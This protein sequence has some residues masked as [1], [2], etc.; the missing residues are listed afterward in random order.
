MPALRLILPLMA[1]CGLAHA[2]DGASAPAAL[3]EKDWLGD[4]PVVLSAARLAQPQNEAPAAM[5]VID[6]DAIRQ[7][8]ARHLVDLLRLVPGIQVAPIPSDS[9]T[10]TYHGLSGSYAR[11]MQV[12]IDGRSQYSAF[13]LGGVNWDLVPVS[14]DDI[15]RIEVVRGSNSAAFGSNAFLG[16]VNVVTRNAADTQGVAAEYRSGTQGVKDGRLRAGVGNGSTFSMRVT[17]DN[18]LDHGQDFLRDSKRQR[19]VDVRADWQPMPGDDVEVHL[20]EVV[21]VLN[22]G[23]ASAS[24]PDRDRRQGQQ[25]LQLG[26]R[27]AL[28]A[29]D[30]IALNFYRN[31]E[32]AADAYVGVKNTY[33]VPV[34]Y[35]YRAI[36]NNVSATHTFRMSPQARVVWGGEYRNDAVRAPLYFTR[37]GYLDLDVARVFGNLE[38]RFRP[39]L[40]G[41]IGGTW[42]YDSNA[43]TTFAPRVGL[44]WHATREQTLRVAAARAFRSPSLYETSGNAIFYSTTG[45]IVQRSLK[46]DGAPLRPERIDSIELG[47]LGDFP[48]QRL[49]ADVRVFDERVTDRILVLETL[50]PSPDCN[51][52][53]DLVAPKTGTCTAVRAYNAQGVHIRGAE[54]QLKW[55]PIES[56]RISLNQSFIWIKSNAN[57]P[58]VGTLALP[59]ALVGGLYP[60]ITTSYDARENELSNRSA[61][62]HATTLMLSQRL[63][64]GLEL[65]ATYYRIGAMKWT[66]NSTVNNWE[67]LDWRL[68]YPF[69]S[70]PV[71]GE[72]ALTVQNDGTPHAEYRPEQLI[73]RRG[74]V[75]LKL[76]Y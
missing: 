31:D 22:V 34:D 47:W 41:N 17:G 33:T 5:T 28:S 18:T 11:Y 14:I 50:L 4:L 71:K 62:T 59:P 13:F 46:A 61:P 37:P 49:V 40:I 24:N 35:A 56:T 76:E 54:Y 36:R 10:A 45:A 75:S 69:R 57:T 53:T 38:W 42:E 72:L 65:S 3:T 63:P 64:L 1:V 9:A 2:A 68:A 43:K 30:E 7:S 73:A 60:G 16:V 67:R 55:K 66:S 44:N 51:L 25:Y 26:W 32:T 20:G 52:A 29:D 58:T 12:L 27:R 48:R 19:L 39:D 23:A 15:E 74:F 70:G 6:R 21:T 8:G